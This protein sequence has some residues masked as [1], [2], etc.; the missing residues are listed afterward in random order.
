MQHREMSNAKATFLA[1]LSGLTA[2]IAALELHGWHVYLALV[3]VGIG[4]VI[5]F[6]R[7]SRKTERLSPNDFQGDSQCA[8]CAIHLGRF[9]F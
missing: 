8:P 5:G 9:S 4:L 6:V 7:W 1:S 2:I 3:L